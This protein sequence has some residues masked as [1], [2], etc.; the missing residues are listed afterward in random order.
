MGNMSQNIEQVLRDCFGFRQLRPGQEAVV[1]AVMEGRDT[2]AIMP[3][4]GGKSLCYQLPAMCKEGLT[5]VVSP[6]I[7]LMKDQVDALQTR[8][9][10]AAAVNSSLGAEEYRQVQQRLR[11]GELKILYVAPERFA[12]S[13]FMRTLA[14]QRVTLLAVDEA[15]CLSQWGHDFRPD[16]LRLGRVREMLGNPPIVA[17]TATAT[18]V[19]RTDIVQVLRLQDPD[20]IISGFGRDNLYFA[21]SPCE[22]KREKFVRIQRTVAEW[23]KGIVYC[24]TRKNV[25]SVFEQLSASHVNAVA[26]HAGMTDEEREFSQNAFISGQ[27]DVVV[28][29][30]AFGMGIDRSD[31]RFVVHFEIP[32][33]V[34]AYYQEAG[35]AGRDGEPAYCELLFNHADLKTQEFFFEGSNPS[36]GLIRSLYNMLALRCTEKADGVEM[37]VDEMARQLGR[38]VNPMAVGSALSVLLHAGAIVRTD[39]PGK[40]VKSTRLTNPSALFK[41]LN[42]DR[43]R[44]EEKA[45]RDH[46]KIEAMMRYAYSTGCRQKWILDYFGETNTEPCGHCDVCL[47]KPPEDAC[48]LTGDAADTVRK[49]LSGI[50]RACGKNPDGTRRAIYGR[51]KIMAMLR[52]AKSALL[53]DHLLRLSTYGLLADFTDARMRAL[54]R[55]MQN[56]GMIESSGGEMPLL[57]LSPLGEQVMRGKEPVR[58]STAGWLQLTGIQGNARQSERRTKRGVLET[59]QIGTLD[60]ALYA[61]LAALRTELAQERHMPVYRILSNATLRALSTVRPTTEAGAMR[62]KGIG[63]WTRQH[64]LPAILEVIQDHVESD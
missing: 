33:S 48:E 17:L 64:T 52:G 19:V 4:G 39:V 61:K 32:G 25:M 40:N 9:V 26:Y 47:A 11:T 60:R 43:E 15:H 62:I 6:L 63:E 55:A 31:V 44:L 21:V 20:V 18:D 51:S 13:G 58:I 45:R 50:A 3:T 8:G 12:Q 38:D 46:K 16:Y 30:N 42:I 41:D 56:A 14:E 23:K 57:S 24:S 7:A 2:L 27:A 5:V 59:L 29:T 35:R 54:F 49:A 10:P 34:E 22:G 36:I 1:A 53:N 37:S 28:A